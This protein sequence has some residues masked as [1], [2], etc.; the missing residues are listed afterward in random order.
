MYTR[1]WALF[2]EFVESMDFDALSIA[3]PVSYEHILMFISYLH[4]SGFAPTSITTYVTAISFVHKMG[5]SSDPLTHFAVQKVLCAVNRLKGKVDSRLPITLFILGRLN[6]SL[7]ETVS[8]RFHRVLLRAMFITAFFGLFRIGE[9]TSSSKED[10]HLNLSQ[11][12]ITDDAVYITIT[13]FKHNISQHPVCLTLNRQSDSS[14]CPV[15]AMH[16][17]M[18]LRGSSEGP[19]FCYLNGKAVT[20]NFFAQKL[21]FCLN[22]CGFDT[23]MFKCHSFRIGGA[24]YFSSL[25][26]SDD[27][28]KKLGRWN[29]NAF[30]I[31]IRNQNFIIN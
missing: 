7:S 14:I 9:L 2:N 21:K 29:S 24:S 27:Q 4:L 10:V 13:H 31:Y 30:M 26:Y 18:K 17:Y 8:N 16:E 11:C 6:E 12:R 3:L 5:S 15:V 22:F 23:K 25:G 1:A 28:I 20:R 19:L